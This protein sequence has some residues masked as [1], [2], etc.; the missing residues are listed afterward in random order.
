MCDDTCWAAWCT[1][2]LPAPCVW[3][4]LGVQA[5]DL[6]Y[7][8]I[9]TWASHMYTHVQYM[10][11]PY[12]CLW[13]ASHAQSQNIECSIS[14][15]LGVLD[16]VS[17]IRQSIIL[18]CTMFALSFY[19]A[20][21]WKH[22]SSASVAAG[23]WDPIEI[24]TYQKLNPSIRR[25]NQKLPYIRWQN[26]QPTQERSWRHWTSCGEMETTLWSSKI[27]RFALKHSDFCCTWYSQST[28]DNCDPAALDMLR[29]HLQDCELP[30]SKFC[31]H[32]GPNWS[33]VRIR[34]VSGPKS[35]CHPQSAN[36]VNCV[37]HPSNRCQPVQR[38][39]YI[40]G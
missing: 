15:I 1:Q 26:T 10:P 24:S 27:P 33:T 35:E 25:P 28:C 12:S 32:S 5:F 3:M 38:H 34:D 31:Q 2:V 17:I 16:H 37:P 8:S 36:Q 39:A 9:Y 18:V 14:M 11:S 23:H 22:V 40:S 30:A 4:R 7:S 6:I 13:S 19:F 21:G 29:N 20:G